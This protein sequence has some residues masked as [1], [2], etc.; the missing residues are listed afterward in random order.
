MI[1]QVVE[2][3][4]QWMAG[5]IVKQQWATETKGLILENSA[6]DI[7]TSALS[8]WHTIDANLL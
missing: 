5:Y 4:K 6:S 7:H 2:L 3:V 1:Q 8:A